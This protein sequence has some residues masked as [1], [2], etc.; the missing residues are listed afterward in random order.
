MITYFNINLNWFVIFE[1]SLYTSHE[2][3]MYILIDRLSQ[4][5]QIIKILFELNE[6]FS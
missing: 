4:Q 3:I 6:F 1:Y 5:Y 2:E